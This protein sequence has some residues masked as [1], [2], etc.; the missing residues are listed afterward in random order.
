MILEGEEAEKFVEQDKK[1]LSKNQIAHL[2]KCRKIYRKQEKPK[3]LDEILKP[4]AFQE[5]DSDDNTDE[6]HQIFYI[7]DVKKAVAEWLKQNNI[8]L[9]ETEVQIRIGS[10]LN[11]MLHPAY[12]LGFQAGLNYRTKMLL[13]EAQQK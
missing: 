10:P 3:T 1:P 6:A 5:Y 13:G 2:E 9:S 4:Y 12:I 11:I 7:D 8:I